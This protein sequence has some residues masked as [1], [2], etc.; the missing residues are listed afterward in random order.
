VSLVLGSTVQS[1]V[2]LALE[3]TVLTCAVEDVTPK[4]GKSAACSTS[5]SLRSSES[6]TFN[7]KL[8]VGWGLALLYHLEIFERS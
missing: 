2:A 3:T 8:V 6:A 5:E 1:G 4:V 7:L